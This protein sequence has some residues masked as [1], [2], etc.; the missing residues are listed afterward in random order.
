MT[1]KARYNPPRPIRIDTPKADGEM[2][3]G[4]YDGMELKAIGIDTDDLIV[5]ELPALLPARVGYLG[6]FKAEYIT[7]LEVA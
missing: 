3:Q 6:R 7:F 1:V 2:G 5:V 4:F